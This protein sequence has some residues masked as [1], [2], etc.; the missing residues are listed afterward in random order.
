[1]A[2]GD[3]RG[4]LPAAGAALLRRAAPV[5]ALAPARLRPRPPPRRG[6]VPL[7]A[8]HVRPGDAGGRRD[9]VR[10]LLAGHRPPRWSPTCPTCWTEVRDERPRPDAAR[11]ARGDS[12]A[13]AGTPRD[14]RCS[15]EFNRVGVLG[16]ADVHVAHRL[17]RLGRRDRRER[18]ARG[19]PDGARAAARV[20]VPRARPTV[21][22]ATAVEGV[23]RGRG[24]G[25][26]VAR[27][28]G[29][30]RR[31][32]ASPLVAVGGDGA[33][34]RPLRLVG[35]TALPRPL[36]AP[37]AL[38]R[39]DARRAAGR[40]PPAVDAAGCAAPL[41]RLF[42]ARSPDRQRLAAVVAAHRWVSVLAGGPGTGKTTT[43]AQAARAAADQAGDPL[44]VALA[45][46]TGKAAARLTEAVARRGRGCTPGTRSGSARSRPRRCTGCSGWR[47][48]ARGRF[49]HDRAN[50]LPYD[51]VVVDEASMVSLTLMA[52]LRRGAASRLPAGAR[53]R[54]RPARV[55]RGRRGAGR[56]GGP[57][58]RPRRASSRPG[59]S[60]WSTP[61]PGAT[62]PTP[63][64]AAA[65]HDGVVRL[66]HVHRF[67]GDILDLAE[68]VRAGDA[69]DV[70][71]VLAARRD[72]VELV[73]LDAA[74]ADDALGGVARGRRRGAAWRWCAAAGR[75]RR[76]R[77][78]ERLDRHRVLCA[79]REGAY[80]VARWSR[81]CEEW[82]RDAIDGYG[83]DGRW[84]VGRP[85]M[86][87]SND[88]QLR[89]FN[90]D[91]GVVVAATAP[92]RGRPSA[93]TATSTCC[94]SAGCRRCRPCTRCR[95]TAARAASSPG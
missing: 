79:H 95:C 46:P 53:R 65:L 88:Y 44:R 51:V 4:A 85:L 80:G 92:A 48:G 9:A 83:R 1:M 89:L 81:W 67:S 13:P 36:L 57:A 59:S 15:R 78:C 91:T 47:P 19:R 18:A 76:R 45:A 28:D 34:D 84:Y 52:R 71:E 12:S 68:A 93:A 31:P 75:R 30:G 35:G 5:P 33:A 61:R 11:R 62:S 29:L 82:L 10:R 7:P 43:V 14:R 56:P 3:A 60:S 87:T 50:R 37:G 49:R 39:R 90:G 22:Q 63:S 2:R 55:G 24:R 73:D 64:S 58:R 26:A 66:S 42:P 16:A 21:A 8:R 72:A 54:P 69:D 94:R 32:R 77:R 25:A 70:L 6:A 41:A 23:D 86:V 20:G 40:P 27:A 17:G 74:V 38:H